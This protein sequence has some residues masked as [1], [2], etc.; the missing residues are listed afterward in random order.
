MLK[1]LSFLSLSSVK[2]LLLT[3]KYTYLRP[4][5]RKKA[6]LLRNIFIYL[7][8]NYIF[9]LFLYELKF[10]NKCLFQVSTL[11]YVLKAKYVFNY[12]SNF[13]RF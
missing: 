8:L 1:C 2:Y 6:L 7:L 13:V 11:L 9:I 10:I 3:S 12:L 4:L 5:F